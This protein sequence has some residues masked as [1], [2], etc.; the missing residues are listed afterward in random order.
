VHPNA[1]LKNVRNVKC[2]LKAR[3]KIL[4]ILEE[5]PYDAPRIAKRT[6]LSYN[7]VTYHLHLLKDEGIVTRNGRRPYFWAATGLG[8]K[9]LQ[10]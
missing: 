3:S 8:Q 5:K 9:R 2:G 7:V 1:Y 4:E 10:G 6:A